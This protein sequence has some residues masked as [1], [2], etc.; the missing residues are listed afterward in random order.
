MVKNILLGR[1]EQ[2]PEAAQSYLANKPILGKLVQLSSVIQSTLEQGL[3]IH[4]FHQDKGTEVAR[5][6]N[7]IMVSGMLL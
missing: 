2:R 1:S 4:A 7:S 5:K 6:E 3:N